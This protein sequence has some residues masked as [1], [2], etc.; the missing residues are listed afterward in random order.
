MQ[1]A[2]PLPRAANR[3]DCAVNGF[4][5][6]ALKASSLGEGLWTVVKLC[7]VIVVV[8]VQEV[9]T[10]V[11]F[12]GPPRQYACSASCAAVNRVPVLCPLSCSFR[13]G[14]SCGESS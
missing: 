9:D 8:V 11:F 3:P 1:S 7:A 14:P 12:R 4:G 10:T 6:H 5:R 13:A 2:G